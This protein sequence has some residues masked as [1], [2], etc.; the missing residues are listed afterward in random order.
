MYEE[1]SA[2]GVAVA[3]SLT[4]PAAAEPSVGEVQLKVGPTTACAGAIALNGS[5][6]AAIT[7]EV[8]LLFMQRF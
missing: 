7:N 3:R 8:R 2:T 6:K 1:S 4:T 5:S